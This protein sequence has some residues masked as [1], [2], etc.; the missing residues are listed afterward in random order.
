MTLRENG[1][2]LGADRCP[3]PA[4]SRHREENMVG[5]KNLL[6]KMEHLPGLLGTL[7]QAKTA[8]KSARDKLNEHLPGDEAHEARKAHAVVVDDIEDAILECNRAI[9]RYQE[10]EKDQ[11]SSIRAAIKGYL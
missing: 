6:F 2:Q 8:L 5:G 3:N 9:E 4:G 7:Q 10:K 1:Q 11:P